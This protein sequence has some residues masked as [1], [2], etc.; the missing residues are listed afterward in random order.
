MRP[1][2]GCWANARYC[3][4][5]VGLVPV[6][7]TGCIRRLRAIGGRAELSG[8]SLMRSRLERDLARGD[9]RALS[10]I[11]VGRSFDG[12]DLGQVERLCERGFLAMTRKG[13]S[14]MTLKGWIAIL[15]RHTIARREHHADRGKR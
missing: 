8:S 14:R 6:V 15:L 2:G 1:T 12:P 13:R 3:A 9:L 4:D 10:N 5:S 11:A 7:A